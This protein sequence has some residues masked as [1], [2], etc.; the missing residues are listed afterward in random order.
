[1]CLEVHHSVTVSKPGMTQ[2]AICLHYCLREFSG[3]SPN[4]ENH[5]IGPCFFSASNG[6]VTGETLV[7]ATVSHC[8]KE[9]LEAAEVSIVNIRTIHMLL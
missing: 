6:F 4:R 8:I 3:P 5:R 7:S 9:N 2:R 1:M